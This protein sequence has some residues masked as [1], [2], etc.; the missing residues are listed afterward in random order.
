MFKI[1]AVSYLGITDIR[2]EGIAEAFPSQRIL[3]FSALRHINCHRFSRTAIVD[4]PHRRP[5]WFPQKAQIANPRSS[6]IG[7]VLR[8]SAFQLS[9]FEWEIGRGRDR[10]GRYVSVPG[11]SFCHERLLVVLSQARFFTECKSSAACTP[12]APPAKAS[13]TFSGEP[14]P[15]AS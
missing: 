7:L 1:L 14:Y 4:R 15:P 12:A 11:K 10:V 13:A 8:E 6:C 5:V 3:H 9:D 2:H